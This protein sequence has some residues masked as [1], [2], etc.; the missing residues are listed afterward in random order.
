MPTWSARS[1]SAAEASARTC[2]PASSPGEVRT[3]AGEVVVES[4]RVDH[5]RRRGTRHRPGNLRKHLHCPGR[6][7]HVRRSAGLLCGVWLDDPADS[8]R[9][10]VLEFLAVFYVLG[11]VVLGLTLASTRQLAGNRRAKALRVTPASRHRAERAETTGNH[12]AQ[13]CGSA[14]PTGADRKPWPTS[15][16][17]CRGFD[18][19]RPLQEKPP[20]TRGFRLL[21]V[22]VCS[23]SVWRPLRSG[24]SAPWPELSR[25]PGRSRKETRGT[26]RS[27][28]MT[29][30]SGS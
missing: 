12:F 4:G 21:G 19:R 24:S 5:G 2:T 1:S 9:R 29:I 16:A 13:P 28:R 8:R 18:P 25:M 10:R 17:R 7:C 14:D 23:Q 3:S 27:T 30:R 15:Q 11:G 20:Q 26:G 22:S 6:A